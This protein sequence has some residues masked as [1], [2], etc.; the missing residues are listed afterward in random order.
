MLN[1]VK[2]ASGKTVTIEFTEF[3]IVGLVISLP[4]MVQATQ[5]PGSILKVDK[6][7]FV[8]KTNDSGLVCVFVPTY[9]KKTFTEFIGSENV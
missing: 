1:V 7:P 4:L 5:V 3:N 2:G 8:V 9:A 6:P